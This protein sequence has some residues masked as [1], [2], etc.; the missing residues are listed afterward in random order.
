MVWIAERPLNNTDDKKL[1]R[2][3]KVRMGERNANKI[4]KVLSLYKYIQSQPI[5]S[6]KDIETIAYYDAKKTRPVFNRRTAKSV[7]SLMKQSGGAGDEALVLDRAIRGMITYIQ[8]F[9][10]SPIT[11]A[12]DNAY[13]YMTIL[14]RVQEMPGL[15]EFVDIAKEAVLQTTKTLI[16]GANDVATDI[17]GPAGAV[18]VALPAA[19]AV[20]FVAITHLLEDEL[21]EAF[22][23]VFLAI[24]FIGPTLYKAAG[25]LGKF[26]RK[27]FEHKDTIVGTT[28]MFLGDGVAETV[29]DFIPNMDARKEPAPVSPP[30]EAPVTTG[31]KRFSTRRRKVHKW[32][33]T[34]S[35]KR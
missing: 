27:I 13:Y 10:P 11:T 14:K 24:P 8:G 29:E 2:Y 31:A 7:F 32:R 34:R 25:S 30:V 17:G 9:L 4:V 19:I 3:L 35:A 15:G 1:F 6:Q 21:G 26:G 22:L 12:A 28:S 33:R 20:A 18:A 23:V 16:V 5:R